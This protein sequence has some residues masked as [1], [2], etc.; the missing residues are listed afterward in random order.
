M[1]LCGSCDTCNFVISPGFKLRPGCMIL[2]FCPSLYGQAERDKKQL[3]KKL[4]DADAARKGD[5]AA[6]MLGISGVFAPQTIL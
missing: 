6:R 1:P 3:Q 4:A 5:L 2:Q